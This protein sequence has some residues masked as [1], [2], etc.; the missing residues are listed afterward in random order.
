MGSVTVYSSSLLPPLSQ[1]FV[2]PRAG[3][4]VP[5]DARIL[6]RI[7]HAL[8]GQGYAIGAI[9]TIVAIRLVVLQVSSLG[10]DHA[11]LDPMFWYPVALW[12]TG[13]ALRVWKPEI[14]VL[15]LLEGTALMLLASGQTTIATSAVAAGGAPFADPW[16][17][18][19]D[20]VIAPW[21]DWP[22]MVRALAARSELYAMLNLAYTSLGWQP[23]LLLFLVLMLGRMEQACTFVTAGALSLAVCI[24]VFAWMP[25]RGAFAYYGITMDDVPGIQVSL[26][27]DFLPVLEGLRDGSLAVIARDNLSGL[28]SFPSMHAS[29]ATILALAWSRLGKWAVPMVLLN[30]LMALSAMPVGNHYL[31]DIIAGVALGWACYV[32]SRRLVKVSLDRGVR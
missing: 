16:L 24:A 10:Y 4:P 18:W 17:S 26:G 32:V 31:V 14:T 9:A 13:F 20:S 29:A 28:V 3:Q 1:A 19:A 30:V 15:F 12:T 6:S 23:L 11:S 5:G 8:A 21:L 7:N 25:A 2:A 22:A 27:F